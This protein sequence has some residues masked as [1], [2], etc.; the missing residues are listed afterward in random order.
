MNHIFRRTNLQLVPLCLGLAVVGALVGILA[1]AADH[2]E[3]P[4]TRADLAAD[5]ADVYVWHQGNKLIAVLTYG[6]LQA[7]TENQSAVYDEDVLYSIHIDNNADNATDIRVDARFGQNSD[8]QWG[9]QVE[10]L[11]GVDG[12]VVGAV[13]TVIDAGSGLSVYAGLR[14]DPFFF[15]LEGFNQTLATGTLAFDGERDSVASLNV[16]SI[17]LEMDLAAATGGSDSLAVW[18][19]SGRK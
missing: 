8:G 15:D 1:I 12:P 4:G 9:I 7:T 19:T 13:E 2:S 18:A 3:A 5:I 16:S 6:G 14:D 11:P 10:N 17:V